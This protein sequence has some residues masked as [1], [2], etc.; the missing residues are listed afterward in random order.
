MVRTGWSG[1]SLTEVEHSLLTDKEELERMR[2]AQ[3]AVRPEREMEVSPTTSMERMTTLTHDLNGEGNIQPIPLTPGV[4]VSTIASEAVDMNS[5][6][7]NTVVL[8]EDASMSGRGVDRPSWDVLVTR[9]KMMEDKGPD[10][11]DTM[12]MQPPDMQTDC[13]RAVITVDVCR[14]G[15]GSQ[16]GATGASTLEVE[17]SAN[18]HDLDLRQVR[19]ADAS[20]GESL[21]SPRPGSPTRPKKLN[22]ERALPPTRARSRSHSR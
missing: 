15:E 10:A 19:P 22:M 1:P 7:A 13:E 20:E 9:D 16:T 21:H 18:C 5:E 3:V 11:C 4:V 6:A 2:A 8:R 17:Q 12:L 14:D